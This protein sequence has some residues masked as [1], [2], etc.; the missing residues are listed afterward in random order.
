VEVQVEE[1]EFKSP[2]KTNGG[3]LGREWCGGGAATTTSL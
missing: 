1:R 3:E 2:Q